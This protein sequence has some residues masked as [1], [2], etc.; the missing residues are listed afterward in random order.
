MGFGGKGKKVPVEGPFL[1]NSSGK[2]SSL[3]AQMR[4]GMMM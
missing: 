3:I 2:F 4:M 1:A